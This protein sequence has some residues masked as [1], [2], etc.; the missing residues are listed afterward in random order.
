MG[1]IEAIRHNVRDIVGARAR[2]RIASIHIEGA[3]AV[4]SRLTGA[5]VRAFL[6]MVLVATP[7]VILPGI[8]TDT[9]QIVALLA[10]F[11]GALVFFEYNA[12]YPS[13]IEFRDGAPYNR[14]RYL[15]M[16]TIVVMLSSIVADIEASTTVSRLTHAIGLVIGATLETLEVD[17][18][19][20]EGSILVP[21]IGA[22]GARMETLTGLFGATT[23]HLL[24]S[25]SRQVMQ[26]GPE[27]AGLRAVVSAL[28]GDSN[29]D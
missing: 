25:A 14:I 2:H 15:M 7:S 29:V 13:L 12:V 8:G 21:G 26:A 9:K 22:Q 24:P 6:V 11:G 19:G 20:Y 18:T 27:V 17:L 10:L 28:T 4:V 23:P 3:R 5:A 1:K 16:L